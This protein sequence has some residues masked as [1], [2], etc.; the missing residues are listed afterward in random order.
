MQNQ[1]SG[2]QK[3]VSDVW[4]PELTRLPNLNFRVRLTRC[5]LRGLSRFL[6]FLWTKPSIYGLEN[7]PREGPA[8]M[9][10]N[11]LG[12]PDGALLLAYLSPT[13]DFL[14]KVELV[15]IPVLGPLLDAMGIIWVHRGKPDR[16]ALKVALDGLR[17]GRIIGIAPEGR[18]SLT[19]ALE[20][21]T[22]GAAFLALK[23]GV[24]IVPV[25]LTGTE[26]NRLFGNMKHLRRTTVTLTIGKGYHLP[27]NINRDEGTRIIME[28]LARQLPFEYRG[29][30]DYVEVMGNSARSIMD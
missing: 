2:L 25:T 20:E 16:K 12:D 8:L 23:T 22:D 29:V 13:P 19:G 1:P 10:M 28:T 5:F 18:E 11:H 9:V 15:D 3:P 27:P 21:G 14:G 6:F 26:N 7:Y 30:Y 4:R 24:P 17:H